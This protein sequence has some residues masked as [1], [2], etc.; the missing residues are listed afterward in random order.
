M[1]AKTSR[2]DR[3]TKI[4]S[5]LKSLGY[6]KSKRLRLYGKEMEATSDPFP[7][8][9]GY[10]IRVRDKKPPQRERN[11]QIPLSILTVARRG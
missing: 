10:A 3:D 1:A 2:P 8:D 6:S 7:A 11:I 4:C 5:A 9:G